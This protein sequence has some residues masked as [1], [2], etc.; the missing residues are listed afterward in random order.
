MAPTLWLLFLLVV[1][2]VVIYLGRFKRIS[3]A[4]VVILLSSLFGLWKPVHR[5]PTLSPW[6]LEFL[7]TLLLFR[8]GGRIH[9][10][11]LRRWPT[12]VWTLGFLGASLMTAFVFRWLPLFREYAVPLALILQAGAPLVLLAFVREYRPHGVSVRTAQ[13]GAY[14]HLSLV[15]LFL[16]AFQRPGFAGALER[17]V[18]YLLAS[19]SLGILLG[20]LFSYLETKVS[21]DFYL[22]LLTVGTLAFLQGLYGLLH[23]TTGLTVLI[24]GTVASNTSLKNQHLWHTLDP[25]E[26]PAV[27]VFLGLVFFE[28]HWVSWSA[29]LGALAGG[30]VLPAV[31]RAA[32]A[33]VGFR[34]RGEDMARALAIFVVAQGALP[35][36]LV[37]RHLSTVH[38]LDLPLA[39]AAM[40]GVLLWKI[41]FR[42]ELSLVMHTPIE[43]FW[44]PETTTLVHKLLR[45]FRRPPSLQELRAADFL[46]TTFLTVP[47][48]A[49]LEQVVQAL[50]KAQAHAVPVVDEQRRV[51]GIVRGADLEHLFTDEQTRHL[52]RAIDVMVPYGGLSPDTPAPRILDQMNR[53]ATD[54]LPVASEGK[55]LGVVLKRD[56]L[57]KH[58]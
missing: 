15:F 40:A 45:V 39:L 51:L 27:L 58:V 26:Y 10:E 12:V 43:T 14:V 23:L 7:V 4:G 46:R 8:L 36:W 1:L 3:L 53:L 16:F 5:G 32:L 28:L 42:T 44:A 31:L 20:L 35:L 18:V 13:L 52:I 56:L 49:T 6:V 21:E 9:L 57:T 19:G 37:H 55:I 11:D 17:F 30:V 48:E 2:P 29:L 47:S 25:Y 41:A 22:V 50:L 33:Y 34:T 54:C 24:A 38:W